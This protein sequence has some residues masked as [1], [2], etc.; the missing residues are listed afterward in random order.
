[1]LKCSDKRCVQNSKNPSLTEEIKEEVVKPDAY[2]VR[3]WINFCLMGET[4]NGR[5]VPDKGD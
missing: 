3:N 4:N 2:T 5:K 1:M